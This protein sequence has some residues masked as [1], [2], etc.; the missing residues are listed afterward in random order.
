M[1]ARAGGAQK[2]NI[3]LSSSLLSSASFASSFASNLAKLSSFS[4]RR[5]ARHVAST[6][7]NHSTN[8]LVSSSPKVSLPSV[9]S[10]QR[11]SQGT[12]PPVPSPFGRGGTST[13]ISHAVPPLR[14]AER[15]TGGEDPKGEGIKGARTR[16]ER[17]TAGEDRGGSLTSGRTVLPAPRR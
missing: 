1:V 6:L 4:S 7:L 13:R 14:M 11:P 2:R 9:R 3:H 16:T 5:S 12:S 15:G 17:G 10:A 8:S